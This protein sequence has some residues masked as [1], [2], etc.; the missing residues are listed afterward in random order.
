MVTAVCVII[1]FV[2]LFFVKADNDSEDVETRES[3]YIADGIDYKMV[4]IL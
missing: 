4:V 2:C 3:S 1:L